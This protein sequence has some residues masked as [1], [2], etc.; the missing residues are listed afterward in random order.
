MIM[1][2]SK[3]N[4]TETIKLGSALDS[5]PVETIQKLDLL[6]RSI[7]IKELDNQSISIECKKNLFLL[8]QG[9]FL[10]VAEGDNIIVGKKLR[11]NP[12]DSWEVLKDNLSSLKNFI[13]KSFRSFDIKKIDQKTSEENKEC[14]Q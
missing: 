9:N 6:C 1:E 12:L 14:H 2:I 13:F 10:Q 7:E 11:L 4:S 5:L 8:V 3:A